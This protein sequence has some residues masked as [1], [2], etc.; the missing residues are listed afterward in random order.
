LH[1]LAGSAAGQEAPRELSATNGELE[2]FETAADAQPG[3]HTRR[4]EKR[5]RP[6]MLEREELTQ[7]ELPHG[8][9]ASVETALKELETWLA[10]NRPA[11]FRDDVLELY[12]RFHAFRRIAELYDERYVTLIEPGASARVRLFCVDPSFLLR[13]ALERGRSAVFFSATL[14]PTDYYRALLGGSA[15]DPQMRMESPFDSGRLA[16]LVHDRVRTEFKARGE[17]LAEVV[18]A[19]GALVE[20]RPGNYMIYF[21]SYRYLES[22]RD[23]FRHLHPHRSVLAQ[24]PG[25]TE[26][27]RESFLAAFASDTGETRVGFAVMG[28]IFGEGIDLVG[29]RL[30]GAA[31][32]S[33]GLPQ[34]CVERDVICDHF[35]GQTGSGFDYAYTFPG[36]NRVLQAV[37]R[38]IRSETDRGI[39]L[40]LDTRFGQ[41]RYRRLFPAW[42]R[43]AR[44]ASAA[45]I[46]T[47]VRNFWEQS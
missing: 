44:A 10:Q 24:Q 25:M 16:V 19:I 29:D 15:E 6:M 38:V 11:P 32:V 26:S 5:K 46:R 21:P 1:E 40:L 47:L 39:V 35:E 14:T 3:L 17:S 31:I 23:L 8:L 45:D 7:R 36:M 28:G 37:G 22:A 42:W 9:T 13:Q 30:I 20:G 4:A 27:A 41:H 18:E 12:F 43:V 33:V 34:L 2:L